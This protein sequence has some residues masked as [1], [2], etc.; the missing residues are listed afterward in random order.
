MWGR[1]GRK[2]GGIREALDAVSAVVAAAAGGRCKGYGS[3]LRPHAQELPQHRHNDQ[4]DAHD[5]PPGHGDGEGGCVQRAKHEVPEVECAGKVQTES[6]PSHQPPEPQ[7]ADGRSLEEYSHQA[8][9]L[10]VAQTKLLVVEEETQTGVPRGEG[11]EEGAEGPQGAVEETLHEENLTQ[12]QDGVPDTASKSSI[13]HLAVTVDSLLL[14]PTK[15]KLSST[16]SAFQP[17]NY[18]SALRQEKTAED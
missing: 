15:Y 16:S 3:H 1:E 5:E 11:A 10:K 14:K 7:C 13:G 6:R 8:P 12:Q 17:F 18:L 2:E 4:R 9:S